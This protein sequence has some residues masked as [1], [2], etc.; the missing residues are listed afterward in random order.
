MS[1]L[2]TKL[3]SIASRSM[4]AAPLL[5]MNLKT[6][7]RA[8]PSFMRLSCLT[9]KYSKFDRGAP[10]GGITRVFG[11]LLAAAFAAGLA[12]VLATDFA[13]LPPFPAAAGAGAGAG[14]DV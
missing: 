4:P 8:L 14:A 2:S 3:F 6:I 1:S 11:F 7:V 13:A 9:E 10:R 5:S 12:A